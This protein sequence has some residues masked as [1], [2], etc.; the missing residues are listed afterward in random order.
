[1]IG[2]NDRANL[3]DAIRSV[4]GQT[5]RHLEVV[6]VDD[7][8]TDGSAERGRAD[9]SR[10]PAGPRGPA[11]REQRWLQPPAQRRAGAGPRAVRHVPRQRRRLRPARVQEPAAHR[12]AHRRRRR[13]RPGRP[14]AREHRASPA[15]GGRLDQAAL[16][17]ACRLRGHPGE[18]RAVLR[19]AVDQQALP[20]RLPGPSRDPLPRGRA[21]RG[22]AVLDQGLLSTPTASRWCPTSSTSGGSSAGRGGAL[23]LAAALRDRQLPRPDR[24]APDDGRLP[25]RAGR[26]RPQGLQGL[27]V[28][29]QRPAHLPVRPPAPRRGLPAV[30]AAA[31]RR[32]PRHG[33][34]ADAGDV[35]PG[36]ADL[37]AH[38][39]A[40][41]PGRDA[42][43]RRLPALRLQ[44]LHPTGGTR[45]PRL[46][47]REPPR[48]PGLPRGAR[49]HGHG[50]A[51]AAVGPALPLQLA[52]LGQGAA[53]PAARRRDRAQ[54]AGPHPARRAAAA[55][56]L[57]PQPGAAGGPPPRPGLVVAAPRRPHRLHGRHRPGAQRPGGRRRRGCVGLEARDRLGRQDRHAAV[58]RRPGAGRRPPDPGAHPARR[59]RHGPPRAV[60][61]HPDEP[62]AQ[63]GRPTRV[64]S[65]SPAGSTGRR[66]GCAR[67]S[68]GGRARP[69]PGRPSRRR[70]TGC[71]VGCR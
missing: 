38:D 33:R 41:G 57:H 28:R 53:W 39:P 64:A 68:S 32:L 65:R 19:P 35:R 63:A 13:R 37:R 11:A 16:H 52:H 8:S 46:L 49:R 58:Q 59:G 14:P 66:C 2:Y 51:P 34:R 23:D 6:V 29:P 27:Q 61:H 15:A 7:A 40:A 25:A 20:S 44:A 48:R 22:L 62:R 5:L 50:L 60:R 69:R 54:P 4:L 55:G 10:G 9:R 42:A 71:S 3:P 18:P 26:R 24:R 36:R 30:D 31:G 70:P 17:P 1:M 43:R 45:R 56:G 12:G 47:E 21:L 67:P